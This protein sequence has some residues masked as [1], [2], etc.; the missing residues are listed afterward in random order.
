MKKFMITILILSVVAT[1]QAVVHNWSSLED[2][3]FSE[4]PPI[5][6]KIEFQKDAPHVAFLKQDIE[7]LKAELNRLYAKDFQKGSPIEQTIN[8]K[9]QQLKQA[10][11][12]LLEALQVGK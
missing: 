11:L 1:T 12:L 6:E 9:Q 8:E 7:R 2:K 5:L 10:E 3:P 4:I